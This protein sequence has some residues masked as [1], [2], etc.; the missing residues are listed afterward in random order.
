MY[1]INGHIYRCFT[2]SMTFER[3]ISQDE[4][5]E[6]VKKTPEILIT[7]GIAQQVNK[8]LKTELVTREN[9]GSYSSTIV[10]IVDLTNSISPSRARRNDIEKELQKHYE[11]ADVNVQ[12]D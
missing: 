10:F 6:V 2:V 4:F 7:K 3:E 11:D 5:D 8:C 12:V 1:I 9:E